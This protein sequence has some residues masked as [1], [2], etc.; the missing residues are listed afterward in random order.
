VIDLNTIILGGLTMN[1]KRRNKVLIGFMGAFLFLISMPCAVYAVPMKINYQGYL[2]DSD[3]SPFDG[4][5]DIKFAI[6][7]AEAA[8]ESIWSEVHASVSVSNGI[9]N[10]ILGETTAIG[11]S[12]LGGDRF[13]GIRV[14]P[15][16]EMTPRQPLTSVAFAIRAEIAESVAYQII[17]TDALANNAVT[18]EK[19]GLG[20]VTSDKLSDGAALAEI[21]DNDG[22]GSSLDADFLDGKEATDFVSIDGGTM[23]GPLSVP[24]LEIGGMIAFQ[25]D[26]SNTF[27]G[28]GAGVAN[29]EGNSNT[30]LGRFAGQANTTGYSNTFLGSRAG[31]ANTEGN[32]NTFLGQLAG[33]A[34]T[35]GTSNVFLGYNSGS[36][37]TTG[38]SNTFLGYYAGNSNTTGA[39]NVFIGHLAGYS[40]TGSN[41]LYIDNSNT[42]NPL[43]YGEFDNDELTINGSATVAGSIAVSGTA[44]VNDSVDVAG[45]V[46]A[47]SFFGDGSGLAGVV[48]SETDPAFIYSPAVSITFGGISNW[49]TAY[50]WGNHSSA[51]YLTSYTETDPEF[52]DSAARSITWGGIFNWNTAYGWGNHSS[53]GYLTSYTE[54]DPVFTASAA[55]SIKSEEISDW[56]EAHGWGDHGSAGYDVSNDPWTGTVDTYTTKGNV[57]IGTP[58]P[59]AALHVNGAIKTGLG[60]QDYKIFEVNTTDSGGWAGYFDY[61]GIA[62][63]SQTGANQQ[64]FMFT[65]GGADQNIFILATSQ[66]EGITWEADFVIKQNGNVGIGTTD[67]QGK[68]DVNGAIYQRGGQLHADYV[69]S[70]GYVLESIEEHT[71]FMWNHKHLKAVPKSKMDEQGREI[72]E[73]GSHR[74][75]ILEE[76]EKAHI[77]ISELNGSIRR[78]Q[79]MI[80]N[81]QK[82]ISILSE[83]VSFIEKQAK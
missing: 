28:I 30:F 76:L 40:E 32:S 82:M 20:A 29:T 3:G 41:K 33:Q 64:M 35:T 21:L 31:F 61:G 42:S 68:L 58:T 39:N 62:I 36:N 10:V 74:K 75:G 48:T 34:N 73:V 81:Q 53:A 78:Q 65:D 50:D 70:S 80:K 25:A 51:G 44:T 37:N 54:T 59:Q 2:T 46:T 14:I 12:D 79:E 45:V 38:T 60:I 17:D 11:S 22:S 18:S 71:E 16:S 77:Y 47:T 26:S 9:F 6:Y 1:S 27:I 5:V 19:I 49:N 55:S 83:K 72:V 69:F 57:G 63:G 67:P 15:D 43:I 52:I 24:S 4:T 13:L 66:N 56:N 8:E 23:T 7:D